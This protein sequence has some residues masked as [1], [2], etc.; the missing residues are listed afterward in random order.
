MEAMRR[1]SCSGS[2]GKKPD[3]SASFPTAAPANLCHLYEKHLLEYERHHAEGFGKQ[4][5]NNVRNGEVL[6]VKIRRKR[7]LGED[8]VSVSVEPRNELNR[9]MKLHAAKA[10]GPVLWYCLDVFSRQ[11]AHAGLFPTSTGPIEVLYGSDLDTSLCMEVN[12]PVRRMQFQNAGIVCLA[13]LTTHLKRQAMRSAFPDLFH[14]QPDMPF[15]LVTMLNPAVLRAKGVPVCTTLQESGNFVITFPRSYHGG[16][17]HG[18]TV[19]ASS[20]CKLSPL[21][22]KALNRDILLLTSDAERKDST[23]GVMAARVSG[24]ITI[25]SAAMV[26]SLAVGLRRSII[27]LSVMLLQ[28]YRTGSYCSKVAPALNDPLFGSRERP[29]LASYGLQR[30]HQLA[31]ASPGTVAKLLRRTRRFLDDARLLHKL[32]A[33]T[34][35][36]RISRRGV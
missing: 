19:I 31:Q 23:S 1:L 26:W 2:G 17:N 30:S 36:E 11:L 20:E 32:C 21:Q 3:V 15:Q 14:A 9:T 34:L 7:S 24:L 6:D 27:T 4:A 22:A 25:T 16:F 10:W 35:E 18:E 33:T 28:A 13:V 12:F 8:E 29:R 5:T